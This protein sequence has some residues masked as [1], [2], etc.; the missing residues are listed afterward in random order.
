MADL[1]MDGGLRRNPEN[2]SDQNHHNTQILKIKTSPLKTVKIPLREQ[3]FVCDKF[4]SIIQNS[5]YLWIGCQ[6]PHDSELKF[7]NKD[8]NKFLMCGKSEA[9][10]LFLQANHNSFIA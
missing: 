1:R 10:L 3:K 6:P 8:K 2:Y 5:R 4:N 7:E 9:W